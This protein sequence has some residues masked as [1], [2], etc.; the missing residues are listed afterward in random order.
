MRRFLTLVLMSMMFAGMSASLVEARPKGKSAGSRARASKATAPAM[1]KATVKIANFTF[2]PKVLTVD[3]GTTVEWTMVAGRHTVE[4]DTGLFKS[5]VLT[6][7]ASFEHK[8]DKPGTYPYH[9][10]FHGEAGG[11]DMA[12]KIVVRRAKK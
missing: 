3:A 2:D 4:S 10:G 8:F 9:C 11:K 12:G 6:E 1:Q 5:P 7:G